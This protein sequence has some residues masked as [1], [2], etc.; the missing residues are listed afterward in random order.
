[1]SEADEHND[2]LEKRLEGI[3]A[4]LRR[5]EARLGVTETVTVTETE[6]VTEPEPETGARQPETGTRQPE[7]EPVTE[8]V[9]V[10]EPEPATGNGIAVE[11][12]LDKIGIGLLLLGL[13][14]LFKL[15]VELGL[16]TPPIKV[17]LGLLTGAGLG[18]A[19]WRV[20]ESRRRLSQILMG[21]SSA[22][23]YITLFAAY[24][25]YDLLPH[26]IAFAGM[27]AVTLATFF[28]AIRQEDPALAVVGALG[29]FATPFMLSSGSGNYV[30]LSI[31]NAILVAGMVAIYAMRGWKSLLSVTAFGGWL[32]AAIAVVMSL[33]DA[34]VGTVDTAVLGLHLLVVWGAIGVVPLLRP[35]DSEREAKEIEA[36][37]DP[38]RTLIVHGLTL[39]SPFFS[40]GLARALW[41]L[42]DWAWST[43]Y[44]I[45]AAAYFAGSFPLESRRSRSLASNVRAVAGL[46]LT[47]AIADY[48]TFD[49]WPVAFAMEAVALTLAA[50]ELDETPLRWGAHILAITAIFWLG[51]MLF[52][53]SDAAGLAFLNASSAKAVGVLGSVLTMSLLLRGRTAKL[54]YRYA[55]HF[56]LLI[57]L[58]D[59]SMLAANGDVLGTACWGIYAIGLLI[60]GLRVDSKHLK[61]TGLATVVLAVGKLLVIDMAGT[62]TIWRVLLFLGFGLALL[63]VS[64]VA[65]VLGGRASS[66]SGVTPK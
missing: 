24:Q 27:I 66:A 25:F 12:W 3:E 21:G 26:P 45:V 11:N 53:G 37:Q 47:L 42:P 64:Y 28:I 29:G 17:G 43:G 4:S 13:G 1:M 34:L 38:L 46:L 2:A 6:T 65:P 31:Y 50:R 62:E 63:A 10:T 16:L 33:D 32:I 60:A 14:F 59:Q 41:D 61:Y 56:L 9:T 55:V 5:I 54:A 48:F 57:Y 22:A 18:V 39:V 49:V 36:K 44:L 23:F 15:S 58:L 52:D 19:G 30:G 20:R 51:F 35:A 7:P 40:L 8:P